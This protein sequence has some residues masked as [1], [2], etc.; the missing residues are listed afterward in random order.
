M[1]PLLILL[2]IA[3]PEPLAPGDHYRYFNQ[4]DWRRRYLVHV[5]VKCDPSQPTPVVLVLHGAAMNAARTVAFTGMNDKADEA[6]FVAVYPEGTGLNPLLTWNAGGLTPQFAAAKPNDVEYLVRVLDDL[7]TVV[8]VDARRVYATGMSNGGMMCYTL[9]NEQSGRI[10]AIAPVAGTMTMDRPQPARPMPVM[11]F[12]GVDDA[13]V[14]F[15]G[16]TES[17]PAFIRFKSVDAT[18]AAWVEA[19]GC[20]KA[21]QVR[22]EPSG[23]RD[24][25]DS[26]RGNGA[27]LADDGTKVVRKT[28]GPGRGGSEVILIVIEG[29]GHTWP[30]MQPALSLLGKSTRRISAN[31]LIWE[32]FQ[33]HSLP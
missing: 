17:G 6:G 28:Y 23:I 3:Q 24:P 13:V 12:H 29:G 9:A 16:L 22:D 21:P 31:D 11:H 14:P 27:R 18:I 4:E 5:P 32:F 25:S 30:G 8:K 10:A 2:A 1:I 20:P 26:S 19:D 15:L 33:R 7:A